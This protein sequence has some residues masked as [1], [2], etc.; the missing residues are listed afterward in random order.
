MK[1]ALAFILSCCALCA[2]DKTPLNFGSIGLFDEYRKNVCSAYLKASAPIYN[3]ADAAS[4]EEKKAF[5]VAAQEL[6]RLQ[7]YMGKVRRLS[8]SPKSNE[9]TRE[10]NKE[11][12]NDAFAKMAAA[13]IK[14]ELPATRAELNEAS[15]YI[16]ALGQ[17]MQ[18]PVVFGKTKR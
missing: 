17:A 9:S 15:K 10:L 13:E 8:L 3:K 12:L 18:L 5:L 16:N 7:A 14:T 6:V 11:K 2:Q 1:Y 4:E